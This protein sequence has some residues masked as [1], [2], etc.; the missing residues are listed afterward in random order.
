MLPVE[1]NCETKLSCYWECMIG[2]I[3]YLNEKI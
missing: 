3:A 1:Y 2:N